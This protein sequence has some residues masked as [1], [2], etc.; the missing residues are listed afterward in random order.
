M[1]APLVSARGLSRSYEDGG[2]QHLVLSHVD[3]D[4]HA[5]QIVVVVG[6]SGSGKSTL[7][8]LLGAMD[9]PST[10]TLSIGNTRLDTLDEDGRALFRRAHVGFVFQAF[11]LLPTLTVLENLLLPLELNGS[12]GTAANERAEDLLARLGLAGRG[13]RLPEELSGGEQQ[14][15]AIARALVHNPALVIADEPTGNLDLE[16]GQQVLELLDELTRSEGRTLVMATH[17]R[18]VV[19]IADRILSISEGRVVEQP[20]P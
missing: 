15:V 16:T 20:R 19:G 14:R 2:R 17:S 1:N 13:A 11:N 8:N 3:L 6:R 9:S 10:G 5:G 12:A 7:L 4:I 18:E